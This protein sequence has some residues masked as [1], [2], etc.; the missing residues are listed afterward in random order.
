MNLRQL[1]VLWLGIL[2]IVA[3]CLYVPFVYSEDN[4]SKGYYPIWEPPV[5]EKVEKFN[6][7][8]EQ[9]LSALYTKNI[10]YVKFEI[11]FSRLSLQIGVVSIFFIGLIITLSGKKS[12]I[13]STIESNNPISNSMQNESKKKRSIMDGP[14]QRRVFE[15]MGTVLKVNKPDIE[16]KENK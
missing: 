13:K 7:L 4:I 6:S 11:D 9:I 8:E 3:N 15:K 12:N 10:T 5:E 14:M 1:V 2:I 16:D